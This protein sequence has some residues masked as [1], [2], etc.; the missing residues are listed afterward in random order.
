MTGT[1]TIQPISEKPHRIGDGVYLV[2]VRN[3]PAVS[4]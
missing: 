1:E 2:K 3:L 4:S